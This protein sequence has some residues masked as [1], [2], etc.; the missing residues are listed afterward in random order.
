[1]IEEITTRLAELKHEY[2]IGAEQLRDLALRENALRATLLRISGAIQVLEEINGTAD[3]NGTPSSR[4]A[5]V[6]RPG[7]DMLSVG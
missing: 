1:M 3:A 4:P 5:P 7:A 6:D 2:E